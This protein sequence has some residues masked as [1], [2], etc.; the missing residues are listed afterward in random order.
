MERKGLLEHVG[1]KHKSKAGVCPICVSQP[2]GD[3]NYVSQNLFSH[4]NQRHQYDLD[5]YTD[6]DLD[7]DAILQQVLQASM[8]SR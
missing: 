4:M 1:K 7:D 6:Y 3:P 2:Y 5:T 8:N